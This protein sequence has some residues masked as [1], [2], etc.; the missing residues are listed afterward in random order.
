MRA[1][2]SC[3]CGC[4]NVL[5]LV[6]ELESELCRPPTSRLDQDSRGREIFTNQLIRRD[7]RDGDLAVPL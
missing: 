2:F 3:G 4:V 6:L 7:F 5:I 1:C